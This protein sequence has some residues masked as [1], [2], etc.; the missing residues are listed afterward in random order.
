MADRQK[1]IYFAGD[2][3]LGTK[4]YRRA[5]IVG[6]TADLA[7]RQHMYLPGKGMETPQAGDLVSYSGA[8]GLLW[9]FLD[10]FPAPRTL[11]DTDVHDLFR[12]VRPFKDFVYPIRDMAGL[13]TKE[14]FGFWGN[15]P[16]EE[17]VALLKRLLLEYLS[18]A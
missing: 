10:F 2:N 7:H 3:L 13:H 6:E 11:S 9:P 8:K 12:R 5:I 18:G 17:G 14:G 4:Y 1:Y 16:L 15:A